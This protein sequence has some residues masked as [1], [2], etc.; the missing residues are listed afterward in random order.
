MNTYSKSSSEDIVSLTM[1][2]WSAEPIHPT[3]GR[4]GLSL[5][6][7]HH[8]YNFYALSMHSIWKF[9]IEGVPS[10][11]PLFNQTTQGIGTLLPLP[12]PLH[13]LYVSFVLLNLGLVTRNCL[14]LH[15]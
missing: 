6:F 9:G 15:C 14:T 4:L 5:Y 10:I 11:P 7:F 2:Q 13:P 12:S 3:V 1:L 8:F